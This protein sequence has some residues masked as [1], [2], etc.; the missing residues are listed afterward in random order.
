MIRF[1]GV[2]NAP[3][4]FEA[5]TLNPNINRIPLYRKIAAQLRTTIAQKMKSGDQLDSEAALAKAF[6]TSS[7]TVREA[8]S[9]LAQDGVIERRHGSGTYVLDPLARQHVGLL[10]EIDISHP[11]TSYMARRSMQQVRRLVTAAGLRVRLYLGDVQPGDPDT[12]QQIGR[13]HV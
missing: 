8:L 9:T 12:G 7:L 3:L 13:A 5:I 1:A 2:C 11:R 6:N 10:M 4:H